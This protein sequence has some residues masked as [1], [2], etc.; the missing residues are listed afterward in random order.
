[1]NTQTIRGF[2]ATPSFLTPKKTLLIDI[3]TFSSV[4]I[5]KSGSYKYIESDDFEILLFSWCW[6]FEE[7]HLVDL[8]SGESIPADVIAAL[9]DPSVIKLAWNSAFEI[10]ALNKFWSSPIGQWQDIMIHSLYLGLTAG[11]DI[12]GKVLG[13]PQDK[14]KMAAGKALIRLFC[15]PVKPTKTNGNRARTLPHHEPEKWQLFRDYNRQDVAVEAEIEKRLSRFPVPESIWQEWRLEMQSNAY[16][17]ALDAQLIDGALAIDRTESAALMREAREI[18]GLSNP[19]SAPQLMKWLTSKGIETPDLQKATV[20][21][22]VEETSD[23][24]QHMLRIRQQLSKMSIRKYQTMQSAMCQDGRIRGT[25]QFY[26]A[27]RSGREAGRLLQPQNMARNSMKTLD[28]ARQLVRDKK[29]DSLKMIYGETANV[30]SQLTRTAIVAAPGHK[31]VV[32]DFNAIEARVI[33]WLSGEQWRLD[34][35]N[36]HG[37]IYEASASQMFGV[38]IDS[39]KHGDPVRQQGKVAELANGYGGSVGAM[40]RMD[41]GG[42]I[43]PADMSDEARKQF[44]NENGIPVPDDPDKSWYKLIQDAMIDANYKS[45]VDKWRKASPSIVRMWHSYENAALSVMRTGRPAGANHVIFARES[46]IVNGLDFLTIQLPS[47]RKLYYAHPFI[48]PNQF[49]QD[50]LYYYGLDQ[51]THKWG[52]VSTY[53]GKLTENICQA[54]ARDCLFVSLRRLSNAGYKTVMTIHDEVVNDVPEEQADV[55]KVIEIMRQ[56][57]DWAPGLPLNADGFVSNYYKKE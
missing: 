45:I 25:M 11:L 41:F 16:G 33:A 22:L 9:D 44:A 35:F 15:K 47:G 13:L 48:A 55:Q 46:D 17:I 27:N 2:P 32:A 20:A 26:G 5:T 51:M 34:V 50:A 52:K 18:T 29:I 21:D 56:P 40:K 8:L 23:E 37:K 31:I 7:V 19:N 12:T 42:K 24:V 1:M 54:I 39:I 10:S 36:T 53:G 30:L 28:L 57:I 38:P 14:R 6:D 3:E 43:R 4:D 49:D